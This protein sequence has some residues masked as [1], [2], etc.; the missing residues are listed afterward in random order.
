MWEPDVDLALMPTTVSSLIRTDYIE[1]SV[2]WISLCWFE[3]I[4]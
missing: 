4:T 3:W 2:Y 1:L